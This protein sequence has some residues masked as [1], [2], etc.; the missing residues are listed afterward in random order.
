MNFEEYMNCHSANEWD[1]KCSCD[2]N[3]GCD[4]EEDCC[5]EDTIDTSCMS[6]CRPTY[7]PLPTMG[8]V[9]V[10]SLLNCSDGEPISCVPF[11]LYLIQDGCEKLVASKKTD[12][13]GKVEFTCLDNGLYRIQQVVDECVFECPEYYP[14]REFC[15]TDTT[16]CQ[17]VYVINKLRKMD[18]C[19]KKMID[20]AA[21]C[22]VKRVLARYCRGYRR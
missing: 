15:I 18:K 22:A 20:Q 5:L 8:R 6:C 16:K 12:C 17:R 14:G 2:C 13:K 4:P 10:Y 21:E 9:E 3:C 11:N 19:L 7:K 1:D